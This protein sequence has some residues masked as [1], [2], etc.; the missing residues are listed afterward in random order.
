MLAVA[1]GKGGAGKT[2]TTLGLAG[3][4]VRQRRTALA[5]DADREMPDL[6]AMAG[7]ARDPGLDAVA[8]GWPARLVAGTADP[9][10]SG[11]E[12][13]PAASGPPSARRN[14]ADAGGVLARLRGTADAVLL[15]CPAGAGPDAVAPLRAADAA[16]V[17]TTPE[18]ACL[19]DAAKTAAMARELDTPV[20][21]AVVSRGEVPPEGIERLLDCPVLGVVPGA[22]DSS[23]NGGR[24]SGAEPLADGGVRAAYDR[25]VS[26]LQPKYL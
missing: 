7:V 17:V 25:L 16:V 15:D 4:L 11:V 23:D 24:S 13:L 18:P 21:G 14:R 6:H 19:R 10:P 2:T 1:G 9:P 22:G 5:A 8:A 20:A 26:A 12:V 3:A